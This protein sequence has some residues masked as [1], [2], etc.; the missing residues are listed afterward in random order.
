[1]MLI[2]KFQGEGRREDLNTKNVQEDMIFGDQLSE[3]TRISPHLK[4][5]RRKNME[6]ASIHNQ[7][8]TNSTAGDK[9]PQ[10]PYYPHCG[11][12]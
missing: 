10:G 8:T 5:R 7:T 12:S 1:M 4:S 9:S 11:P 6:N 3:F 2:S